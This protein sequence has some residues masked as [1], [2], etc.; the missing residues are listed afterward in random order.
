MPT[1][2]P[3]PAPTTPVDTDPA[4]RD[5]RTVTAHRGPHRVLDR[6]KARCLVTHPASMHAQLTR[7]PSSPPESNST[8]ATPP[9][10]VPRRINTSIQAGEEGRHQN[11]IAEQP[12]AEDATTAEGRADLCYRLLILSPPDG[13]AGTKDSS[14]PKIYWLLSGHWEQIKPAGAGGLCEIPLLPWVSRRGLVVG[15][16]NT[17][18]CSSSLREVGDIVSCRTSLRQGLTGA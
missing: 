18:V 5:R 10:T 11:R 4:S 7:C 2:G 13:G 14:P 15:A 9:G 6:S 17:V 1:T 3:K 8:T 12:W 16:V